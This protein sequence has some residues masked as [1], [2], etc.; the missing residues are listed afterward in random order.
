[1]FAC[2]YVPYFKLIYLSP[3]APRETKC[4][5]CR[6]T[7][8]SCW[9]CW[10]NCSSSPSP[11]AWGGCSNGRRTGTMTTWSGGVR[12]GGRGTPTSVTSSTTSCTSCLRWS[13]HLVCSPYLHVPVTTA[14]QHQNHFNAVMLKVV[15][16]TLQYLKCWKEYQKYD[17]NFIFLKCQSL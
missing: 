13:R 1:M 7:P 6:G 9:T 2:I 4:T 5:T 11:G 8:P 17:Y 16:D 15:W 10:V 14:L 12:T 3:V